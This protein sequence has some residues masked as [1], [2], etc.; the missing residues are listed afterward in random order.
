MFCKQFTYD[1]I[2]ADI[3]LHATGGWVYIVHDMGHMGHKNY[4]KN[5][6]N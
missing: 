3:V 1:T 6:K 2:S 5:V 4:W